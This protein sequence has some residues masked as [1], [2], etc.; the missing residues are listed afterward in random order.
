MQ[1]SVI[2]QVAVSFT[3]LVV[4]VRK[5]AWQQASFAIKDSA[6]RK[7]KFWRQVLV[8]KVLVSSGFK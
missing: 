6:K 1:Q 3:K 8:N 4:I 7:R 2:S 5:K